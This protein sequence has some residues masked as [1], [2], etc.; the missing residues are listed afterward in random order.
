MN[1]L[2]MCLTQ[3]G[4]CA[5]RFLN[6]HSHLYQT[7]GSTKHLPTITTRECLSTINPSLLPLTTFFITPINTRFTTCT[8]CT[9]ATA[10]QTSQCFMALFCINYNIIDYVSPT[11]EEITNPYCVSPLCITMNHTILES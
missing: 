3:S 2:T 7:C 10:V 8:V 1:N 5:K 11:H 6:W 4:L 9:A